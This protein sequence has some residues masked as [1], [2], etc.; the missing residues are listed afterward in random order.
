MKPDYKQMFYKLLN[1][2]TDAI[3]ILEEVQV[4]TEEI[5]IET[6]GEICEAAE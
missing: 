4:K 1:A 6:C 3:E 2:I 5:Y